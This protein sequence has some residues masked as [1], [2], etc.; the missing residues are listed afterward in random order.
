MAAPVK[1]TCPDI[2]RVIKNLRQIQ[3][4]AK[5]G[6]KKFKNE[7]DDAYELFKDCEWDIDDIIGELED[8]RKSNSS[9]R[10]W[11]ESLTDE[12]ES[13]ANYINELEQK[14]EKLE[15]NLVIQ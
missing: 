10:E 4:A 14:I 8:L 2:D 6:M 1:N 15:N 12:L 9:L 3:N 5:D 11:G 13:S 7:N